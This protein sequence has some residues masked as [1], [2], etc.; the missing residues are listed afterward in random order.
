MEAHVKQAVDGVEKS[1]A[2]HVEKALKDFQVRRNG[3]GQAQDDER[4]SKQMEI[5]R[6]KKDIDWHV[7]FSRNE[8]KF[9]E[10]AILKTALDFEMDEWLIGF[11]S[12]CTDQDNK[13]YEA[14]EEMELKL[15]SAL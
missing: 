1:Y 5:N 12:R 10:A 13:L 4:K 6:K 15:Q 7:Q 3:L 2:A 11:E 9:E 8:D 14:E